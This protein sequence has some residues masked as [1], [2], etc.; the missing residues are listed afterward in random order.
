MSA[1]S[2]KNENEVKSTSQE[3]TPHKVTKKDRERQ[4]ELL[5]EEKAKDLKKDH[6][7]KHGNN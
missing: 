1:D 3:F 6:H 2:N 7:K 4:Q 5:R